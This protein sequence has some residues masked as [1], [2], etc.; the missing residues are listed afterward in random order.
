MK[1]WLK[2]EQMQKVSV[3]QSGGWPQLMPDFFESESL[4]CITNDFLKVLEN[5]ERFKNII[6][7]W[8]SKGWY[9]KK[10]DF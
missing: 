8:Q 6:S 10:K 9:L 2:N 5:R 4:F 7:I 3:H 1:N